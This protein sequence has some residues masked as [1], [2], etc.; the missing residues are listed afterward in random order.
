MLSNL[1]VWFSRGMV[2]VPNIVGLSR[3]SGITTITSAGLNYAGDSSITTSNSSLNNIIASQ[4]PV[5]GTLVDYNSDVSFVYYTYVP[6]TTTATTTVPPTTTSPIPTTT[7]PV[8]TTSSATPTTTIPV[9]TTS[10]ATPTTTI[11]VTTTSSATPT[12]TIPVTTTSSVVP[13]TTTSTTTG[14]VYLS[15][16]DQNGNPVQEQFTVD[17]NNVIVQDINQACSVYTTVLTNIGATSI[18]CSTSSMPAAPPCNPTTPTTTTTTPVT[19]TSSVVPTTTTS[20]SSVVCPC[21]TTYGTPISGGV[22]SG[23]CPD[24]SC[25]GCSNYQQYWYRCSDG[26]SGC[27]YYVGLGC[28]TPTTTTSS[29]VPTTTT[30]SAVPTTTTAE[31]WYCSTTEI[32]GE[33]QYQGTWN[34]DVSSEQCNSYKTVCSTSGY[35]AY[36][37]VPTCPPTTTTSS[38][39][40]TTTTSSAVP[41]TTTSAAAP[42]GTTCTSFDVAIQCCYDQG[43]NTGPQY[44]SSGSACESG[45]NLCYTGEG[46]A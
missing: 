38:A 34:A 41:T 26:S 13:T 28:S 36:P 4:N 46:C 2:Q 19:T 32:G 23:P 22:F 3:T 21:D 37:T 5:S 1:W 29:A 30:S 40:P 11:P 6:V 15:Y 16:C 24:G 20:T 25:P 8:T 9:T 27:T 42:Q 7:I 18:S 31:I 33:G 45:G 44:C 10:S 39:V 17:E 43:C 12:T 35:P 14:T